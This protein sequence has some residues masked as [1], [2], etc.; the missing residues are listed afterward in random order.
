MQTR[1]SSPAH[2]HTGAQDSESRIECT[3]MAQ[4]FVMESPLPASPAQAFAWH[5]RPGALERLVPPFEKVRVV[6]RTGSIQEGDRVVMKVYKGPIPITWVAEHRDY[7][8]GVSFK[9]VQL[10]GPFARWEHT[11]TIVPSDDGTSRLRDEIDYELPL[12]RLGEGFGAHLARQQI[13]QMFRYRHRVTQ[14][15]LAMH[16][17]ASTPAPLRVAITGATGLLGS[18]LSPMLTTGGHETIGLSRN[19]PSDEGWVRWSRDEGFGDPS[20]LEGL[21]AIVHL[22]GENIAA[23]RWSA[24]RKRALVRSR[25]E[26]T[27]ALI[28]ALGRLDRPPKTFV[29]ASAVGYYGARGDEPLDERSGKGEGFLADLCESWEQ[30]ADEA[31]ALGCRVVK[32]RFGVVLSPRGGMLAKVLP[33]FKLGGGGPVGSGDQVLSWVL[34]DD[35]AG[36]IHHALTRDAIEGVVNVTAPAPVTSA[37]FARVL[38]EVIHRPAFMP[39]PA[40]ALKMVYGEMAEAIL[41][42]GQ[43]VL[44]TRLVNSG[45]EF[46]AAKLEDALRHLLGKTL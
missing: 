31:A 6:S 4:R 20:R 42:T 29:S 23:G 44:P 36:A 32:L 5:E 8:R 30:S 25:V 45:Y 26:G 37:E 40:F 22:A 33:I 28:A 46:R 15:D 19:P 34:I 9:D 10:E 27:R 3:L 2:S 39:A 12:G 1:G 18:V 7:R 11:H 35:A 21:D 43:R 16:A 17:A 38:G 24:S 14:E 41:L 13:V